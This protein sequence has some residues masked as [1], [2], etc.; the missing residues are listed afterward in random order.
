MKN[1]ESQVTTTVMT[2][3][4]PVDRT[5]G[6]ALGIAAFTFLTA[7]GAFIR[8]PLPFTPVPV[9][10]QVFFVL[11]GALALGP[12]WG[13]VSQA[14]YLGLGI[15]GMPMF[16]LLGAGVAHLAGPTGGYIIGFIAAQPVVGMIAGRDDGIKSGVI[17]TA[18]ALAAG[19]AVIYFF[20]CT[21]LGLL[22]GLEFEK[23]LMLGLVPF[24]PGALL[25]AAAAGAIYNILKKRI[26]D[27]VN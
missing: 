11:L 25:K 4:I 6:L 10:M 1:S 24:I 19:L 22:T 2:T 14:A 15:A 7:V 23:V 5:I 13:T 9:T 20:G 27:S 8:I 18:A 3:Q 12:R 16:T 17:R 21:H 26:P